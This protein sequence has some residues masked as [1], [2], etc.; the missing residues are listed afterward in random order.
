MRKTKRPLAVALALLMMLSVLAA[1][2]VFEAGAAPAIDYQQT[3]EINSEEEYVAFV[4]AINDGSYTN[5]DDHKVVVDLDFSDYDAEDVVIKKMPKDLQL[6]FTGHTVS[7]IY[8]EMTVN[9]HVPVGLIADTHEGNYAEIL[10]VKLK[11][12]YLSVTTESDWNDPQIGIVLGY[13]DRAH[14]NNV[15][16]ENVTVKV[17]G[18]GKGF[19]GG[20]VGQ[21]QWYNYRDSLIN[22]TMN[23][24]LIDAPNASFGWVA[25]RVYGDCIA[26]V[27]KMAVANTTIHA[28][29][30]VAND[31]YFAIAGDQHDNRSFT[32]KDDAEINVNLVE[33]AVGYR[34]EKT[35]TIDES[36][37][38]QI[39]YQTK[40]NEDGTSD[41]RFIVVAKEAYIKTLQSAVIKASFTTK[42]LNLE[43]TTVFH[44]LKATEHGKDFTYH[45]GD[46]LVIVGC[47]VTGVPATET[48]VPDSGAFEGVA[49]Q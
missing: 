22:I 45:A 8:R 24:V 2:P 34:P 43:V 4:K 14:V 25:G 44:S 41:Y 19:V 40:T 33:D 15:D 47:V 23:N 42:S 11:D 46:N 7:G 31:T 5:N 21:Y 12:C 32:K 26:T 36:A 13:G 18:P 3:H 27:T 28:K 38:Y 6:D 16:L 1:F 17:D 39:F 10:N 35:M 48:L 37:N 29:N 20:A 49:K 30:E 9:D